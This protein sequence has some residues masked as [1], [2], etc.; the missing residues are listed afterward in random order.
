LKEQ[1]VEYP[2]QVNFIDKIFHQFR[3]DKIP[4]IKELQVMACINISEC[5]VDTSQKR[6]QFLAPDT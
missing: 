3:P 6:I 5:V 1:K 2:L 4:N